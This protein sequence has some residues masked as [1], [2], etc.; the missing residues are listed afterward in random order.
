MKQKL[1]ILFLANKSVIVDL[2]L[3]VIVDLV[4]DPRPAEENLMWE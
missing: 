2:N 1:R 4:T 3:K